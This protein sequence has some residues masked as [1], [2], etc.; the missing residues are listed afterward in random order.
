M[1]KVFSRRRWLYL[2]GWSLL[3][4]LVWAGL[5][6]LPLFPTHPE[7]GYYRITLATLATAIIV[8]CLVGGAGATTRPILCSQPLTYIGKVSYGMYVLHPIVLLYVA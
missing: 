2:L 1:L 5:K 6:Q 4:F 8:A 7:E 3:M